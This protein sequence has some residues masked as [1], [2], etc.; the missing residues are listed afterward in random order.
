[1]LG[2]EDGEL[3]LLIDAVPPLYG[4]VLTAQQLLVVGT[5]GCH[6]LFKLCHIV[7]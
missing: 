6:F 5:Q 3:I 4:Y 1:M 2:C 7:I